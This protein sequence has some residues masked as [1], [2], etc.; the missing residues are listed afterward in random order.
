MKEE[1]TKKL[2]YQLF[3]AKAHFRELRRRGV[4][5]KSEIRC[6]ISDGLLEE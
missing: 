4:L 3:W 6:L 1:E 2:E 5:T